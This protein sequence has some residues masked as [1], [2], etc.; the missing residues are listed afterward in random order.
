VT[1]FLGPGHVHLARHGKGWRPRSGIELAL[2][3]GETNGNAW[4]PALEALARGLSNLRWQGADARVTVS[5]HFVRYA[6]VPAAGKL[7]GNAERVA[8]A[9]HALRATFGDRAD[10]WQVVLGDG[11][12]GG[13]AIAA[14]IEAELVEGVAATL[15]AANLRAVAVEP[16]LAAAFNRCRRSINGRAAWLAVAEPGRLCVAYLDQGGWQ[17]LHVERVRGRLGDEL[18]AALERIRLAGGVDAGAGRVLLVSRDA[19][20]V[21]LAPESGWSVERVRLGDAQAT[22]VAARR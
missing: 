11:G 18:A 8:A 17:R 5:N 16:L 9:R 21:E 2:A 6:L 14:G 22:P 3:C 7:R 19:A 13:T 20:D 15:A 10:R 4:Q 12:A 1:V